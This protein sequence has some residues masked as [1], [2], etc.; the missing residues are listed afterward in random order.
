M[1]NAVSFHRIF[2]STYYSLER[3]RQLK[4]MDIL[5]FKNRITDET[6]TGI[7]FT[8]K[9]TL[10]DVYVFTGLRPYSI[11]S[12]DPVDTNQV[13]CTISIPIQDFGYHTPA[14][15]VPGSYVIKDSDRHVHV[16]SENVFAIKYEKVKEGNSDGEHLDRN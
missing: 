12:I 1:E 3:R 11:N 10:D 13:T 8:G 5:T 15:L 16:V 6:V 4:I 2:P 9:D 7:Q 14:V